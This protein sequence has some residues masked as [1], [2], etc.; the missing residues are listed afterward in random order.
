MQLNH[1]KDSLNLNMKTR[2]KKTLSNTWPDIRKSCDPV[3]G[4]IGV[5][6][7]HHDDDQARVEGNVEVLEMSALVLVWK[8]S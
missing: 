6:F 4:L 7:G 5:V 8:I 2:T 1:N 3:S